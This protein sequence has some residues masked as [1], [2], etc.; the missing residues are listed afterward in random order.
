MTERTEEFVARVS[1]V[2]SERLAMVALP[3]PIRTT[4]ERLLTGKL[5]RTRLAARLLPGSKGDPETAA[6]ACAAVELV[7]TATLCHDDVI[8]NALM[9]RASPTL[10]RQVGPTGA[11]LA[12][13]LL[14]AEAISLAADLSGAGL[15]RPFLAKIREV[16]AAEFEHE[17]LGRG[18]CL[19][20]STCIRIA[21]GKTGA[22]FAFAA[23]ACSGD[24]ELASALDEAGYRVGTAY[25]LADDLLDQVGREEHAGKTLGT[26]VARHKYTLAQEERTGEQLLRENVL[27]LCRSAMAGLKPWPAVRQGLAE[28]LREEI[29]PVFCRYGLALDVGVEDKP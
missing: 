4:L 9:R 16:C 7:H 11:I 15:L 6:R 26:D 8:D 1:A 23:H 29:H 10:W 5:L 21:R 28:W 14:L 12:G 13:D 22:L 18:H 2:V 27:D 17:L 3:A 25:Q 20:L 19:D 24:P